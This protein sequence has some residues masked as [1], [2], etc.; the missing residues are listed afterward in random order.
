[1]RTV[2]ILAAAALLGAIVLIGVLGGGSVGAPPLGGPPAGGAGPSSSGGY[3]ASTGGSAGGASPLP[4]GYTF[5]DDFDGSALSPVWQQ[6]FNF[7]GIENTWSRDQASVANGILSIKA[8]RV[9][10]DGWVSALLDTK[11][12]WTQQYGVFEARM[13]IPVGRG[14]WPAFWSYWSAA[15]NESEIDTM[16]VCANPL[17]AN[18]GNDITVLHTTTRWGHGQ[19]GHDTIAPNL[20]DG[21]HVYG[22]EWRP[23]RVVYTLDGVEVSRFTEKPH[24]PKNP[25]PLIVDLAVG[26]SWCGPSDSSTP[27]GATLQ[28]DWIRAAP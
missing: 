23:D 3:G 9:A 2:A 27:D 14:L 8:S 17:G 13:K 28:V 15:G 26:G 4:S 19:E 6:N 24:I 7:E 21:F 5:Y 1:M 10:G 25:M 22:V 11:G 16:E 12:T 18:D 20:S